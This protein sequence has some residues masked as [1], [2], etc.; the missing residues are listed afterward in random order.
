MNTLEQ[1]AIVLS[2]SSIIR[3]EVI[4]SGHIFYRILKTNV[5]IENRPE[6]VYGLEVDST[7]FGARETATVNDVSTK[8]ELVN[9]L[10][11]MAVENMV[12]PCT[13]KD[14]TYD[15]LVANY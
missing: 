13:L 15:F 9:Q 1:D 5:L 4:G 7:L 3:E 8:F 14:V 11:E 10:F 2:D 12:L 6:C